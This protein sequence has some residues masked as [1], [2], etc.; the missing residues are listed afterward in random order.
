MTT[1][2]N[3]KDR[4]RKA[5]LEAARELLSEGHAPSVAASA[6]RALISEATAYRYFTSARSL[7]QEALVINWPGLQKVLEDLRIQTSVEERAC[8]AAEIMARTVLAN[9]AQVRALITLSYSFDNSDEIHSAGELRP[10]FRVS[11]IEAVLEIVPIRL[12]RKRLKGLKLALS[13]PISAEAVLCLKDL[14]GYTDKE[15][16]SSLGRIAR[17]L[18]I[19][20]IRLS[21]N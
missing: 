8:F 20:E 12:G 11:L 5:L 18:V 21:D 3:Q 13:V 4:T 17:N 2:I 15:I 19:S 6:K 9:E 7:L 10:A 1:R 14:G 16:I